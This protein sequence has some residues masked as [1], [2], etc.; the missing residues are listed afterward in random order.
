MCEERRLRVVHITATWWSVTNILINR[1]H[2]PVK[3]LGESQPIVS[4]KREHTR[5]N[6]V[7]NS[8]VQIFT[9]VEIS[10]IFGK[11]VERRRL[12]HILARKPMF[13]VSLP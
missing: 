3:W 8:S 9:D 10:N 1:I 11:L 13:L 2:V 6:S 5:L 4:W 12:L 7:K